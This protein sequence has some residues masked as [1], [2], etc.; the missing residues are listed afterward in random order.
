MTE[1]E[2]LEYQVCGFYVSTINSYSVSIDLTLQSHSVCASNP[3]KYQG[4]SLGTPP[5]FLTGFCISGIQ[6]APK[7]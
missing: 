2:K 7:R 6:N 1:N 5:S 3:R 4:D